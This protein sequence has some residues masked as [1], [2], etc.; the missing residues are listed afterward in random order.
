MKKWLLDKLRALIR[1][2]VK[3]EIELLA[4][5]MNINSGIAAEVER[6]SVGTIVQELV[7][8]EL[9]S[10]KSSPN[11]FVACPDCGESYHLTV[12]CNIPNYARQATISCRKCNRHFEVTPGMFWEGISV[13]RR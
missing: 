5:P 3:E 7:R 12:D 11:R 6:I 13:Q 9:A 1:A 2:I 8:E 10:L 4:I